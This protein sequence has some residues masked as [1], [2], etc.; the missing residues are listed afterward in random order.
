M[1]YKITIAFI[2]ILLTLVGI[3]FIPD[4]Q[5]EEIQ[6]PII[7]GETFYPFTV[8]VAGNYVIWGRVQ[9]PDGSSDSLFIMVDGDTLDRIW[10]LKRTEPD[11]FDWDVANERDGADPIIFNFSV[12]THSISVRPRED[13]SKITTIILS[14]DMNFVPN[15]WRITIG[16]KHSYPSQVDYFWMYCRR[17]D[18]TWETGYKWKVTKT[19]SLPD[20]EQEF[21]TPD[22]PA[23]IY[24][25]VVA[26]AVDYAGNES[27]FPF[28]PTDD[29][30]TGWDCMFVKDED[31]E[32]Q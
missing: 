1:L 23:D 15:T 27:D 9:A 18:Q 6:F 10:D 21:T 8:T 29:G 14:N 25:C 19:M 26:T 31:M 3:A 17:M 22:I 12:G 32:I 24:Y 30:H 2:W 28:G 5:S 13:G 4:C 11:K 7:E 16:F 20:E